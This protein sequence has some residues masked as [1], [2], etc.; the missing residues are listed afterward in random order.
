MA[1]R[2]AYT[3]EQIEFLAAFRLFPLDVITGAYNIHFGTDK[4][5]ASIQSAYKNHGIRRLRKL[6]KGK[7]LVYTP[8]MV[9]WLREHYPLMPSPELAAA[10]NARYGTSHSVDAIKSTC[11]RYRIASGRSGRFEKG[12]TSWNKGVKGYMGANATSFKKGT[13]PP[14]Q[15]P[16]WAERICS[17]DGYVY[18]SVP[19]V[20]PYTGHARRYRQKH[21]WLWEQ[22]NGPVPKGCAIIFADCDKYNFALD[23]LLCISRGVLLLLNQHKYKD[24][25]AELRPSILALAKIESAAG[26]KTTGRAP[27][28]GRKKKEAA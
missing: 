15:K 7:P 2:N 20:N 21:V 12:Q 17:K 10:F 14:N 27:G 1:P 19:E 23:N 28:A 16:L 26:F 5:K 8:D 22:A 24:Q 3:A 25:P 9:A 4:A 18:I 11:G 6:S 13:V